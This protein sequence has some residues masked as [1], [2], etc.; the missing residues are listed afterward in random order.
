MGCI[1]CGTTIGELIR[2]APATGTKTVLVCPQ[3]KRERNYA[4]AGGPPGF[5]DGS[6]RC[7]GCD[8]SP[9]LGMFL[10]GP[11]GEPQPICDVCAKLPKLGICAWCGKLSSEGRCLWCPGAATAPVPSQEA[12]AMKRTRFIEAAE[13]CANY[14]RTHCPRCGSEVA[15]KGFCGQCQKAKLTGIDQPTLRDR[16]AMAALVAARDIGGFGEIGE[17]GIQGIIAR[18]AYAIADAMLEARKK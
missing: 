2:C 3:C 4:R 17:T 10:S 18:N 15:V 1:C 6:L 11:G 7:V 14:D 8:K 9:S 12:S 16:F 5:A 13:K